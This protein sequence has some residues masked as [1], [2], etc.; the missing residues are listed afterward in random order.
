MT[1]VVGG[2]AALAAADNQEARSLYEAAL[3]GAG[4]G[5]WRYDEARVRLAYGERLRRMRAALPAREQ[6]QRAAELFEEMGAI[7]LVRRATSELRATGCRVPRSGPNTDI[8]LTE[9]ELEIALLAATGLTNKEISERLYLSHRTVS[10]HLCSIFP[11]LGISRRAA[12]RDALRAL[13]S[14]PIPSAPYLRAS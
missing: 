10:A 2:C 6:L 3:S 5:R 13:G 1:L 4:E 7:P 12:L 14:G 9:Q 11:K 8:P